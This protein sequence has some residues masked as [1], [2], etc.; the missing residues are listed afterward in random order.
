[1]DTEY[2][3]DVRAYDLGEPQLFS[4]ASVKVYV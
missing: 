4:V 1:M 2:Q 3:V